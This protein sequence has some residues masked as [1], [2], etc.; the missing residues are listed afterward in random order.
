MYRKNVDLET[1]FCVDKNNMN[2]IYRDCYSRVQ[3]RM[4]TG[5]R[6]DRLCKTGACMCYAT[7][8]DSVLHDIKIEKHKS[9]WIKF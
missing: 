4:G 9:K 8:R 3:Q 1:P 7:G 6:V 5:I 2:I